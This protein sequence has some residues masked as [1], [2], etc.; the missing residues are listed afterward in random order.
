MSSTKA[1]IRSTGLLSYR[2]QAIPAEEFLEDFGPDEK[3]FYV[4]EG[5]KVPGG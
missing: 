3:Y 5:V 4:G 2:G 1:G